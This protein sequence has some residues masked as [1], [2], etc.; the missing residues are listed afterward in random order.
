[1]DFDFTSLGYNLDSGALGDDTT[2]DNCLQGGATGDQGSTD[3]ALGPLQDNGGPTQTIAPALNSPAV[4]KGHNPGVGPDPTQDQRGFARPFDMSPPN[5]NDGT[6]V[7]AFEH[8]ATSG[9]G[10]TTTPP[11][12]TTPSDKRAAALKKCKKKRTK[13]QRK[14][15]R[16]KANRLVD[17]SPSQV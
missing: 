4:D 14:K 13:R 1:M 17:V 2:I 16:K 10:G 8:T 11:P 3:P 9:G 15:C 12:T 6:D 5:A 7:G